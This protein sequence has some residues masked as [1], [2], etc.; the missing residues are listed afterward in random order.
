MGAIACK[1]CGTPLVH[2]HLWAVGELA[3]RMPAGSQI[4]GRYYVVAPN[5]WLDTQPG[6]TPDIPQDWSE[7]VLPYLYLYPQQLHVPQLYGFC[8][9]AKGAGLTDT[10]LLENVPL[11]ASGQLLPSLAQLW[12]QA[13]AVRQVYWLWQMMQLWQPLQEQGVASSLLIA[14]NL[15]VEG[16]R[17]RL[18]Q[19]YDDAEVFGLPAT[20][21]VPST[22]LLR[23]ADLANF[24]LTWVERAQMP[25]VEPLREIC[26]AMQADESWDAVAHRLNQVLLTQAAQLPLRLQIAG[27]TDPGRDRPHNED[28]TYPIAVAVQAGGSAKGAPAQL[29]IVCDGIGG[30]EGGE[31]ASQ[32]A[33]QALKLQAQALLAEVVDQP[34]AMPPEVV[35]QQLESIVRVVNNLI[36]SQNDVQGRTDRRRMGTTL[37]MALQMPQR[38]TGTAAAGETDAV[39][40]TAGS[41]PRHSSQDFV[42]N[43]SHELYLV[44]V[45]DS[46]A[47]WMT[48]RYCQL[49]TVDDDVAGRETKLGRSLYREALL[50]ADAGGLTQAL[51]TRDADAIRPTVQRLILEEDG[52]LLL[53]S[54]GLSDQGVVE[55]HWPEVMEA[56]MRGQQ[57]L[58]ETT[59]AWVD[60]ANQ[61]NGHDN[62]SVVL[63]HASVA[64]IA[65]E[66]A[67]P[68][69]ESDGATGW[70]AASQA[71]LDD[72]PVSSMPEQAPA[73]RTS[74]TIPAVVGTLVALAIAGGIGFFF[75]NRSR[76]VPVVPPPVAQPTLEQPAEQ[77]TPELVVPRPDAPIKTE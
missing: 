68:D 4:A 58:E 8:P 28:A 51:G 21:D 47:Y 17:L 49:L 2:R 22:A 13:T 20:A 18:R 75:W 71:L 76:S 7:A 64:A 29:A 40:E 26:R 63:L 60:V 31:V 66:P 57:S 16:W 50:R 52:L 14:D 32:M 30:H 12:S 44:H 73:R 61:Q 3:E 54:D 25:V 34:E 39:G 48:E 67:L 37:V 70:T 74:A 65:P 72:G 77:P 33:V 62:I 36:A 1:V 43:N 9:A 35:T 38:V 46:R 23:L 24:W 42:Q 59:Q 11:D 53:C 6:L 69:V 5:V 56:F 41:N 19:L 15:R 45:G 27:A 55:A 10:F